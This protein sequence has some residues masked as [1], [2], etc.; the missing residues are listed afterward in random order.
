LFVASPADPKPPCPI[1][2][3]TLNRNDLAQRSVYSS[4]EAATQP[5]IKPGIKS[6]IPTSP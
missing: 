4:S 6:K 3:T 2:T 5:A 1:L